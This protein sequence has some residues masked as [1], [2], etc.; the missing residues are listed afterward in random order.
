MDPLTLKWVHIVSSTVLFGTGLGTAFQGWF[1]HRTGEPKVIAAV[2]RNIVRAD[3]L[4]TATSG[5]IQPLSGVLLAR[6]MGFDLKESWLVA[7]FALYGL[8]ALCWF[9]VVWIQMKARD[10][11]ADAAVAGVP[12]PALYGRLMRLWFALGWPAFLALLGVFWLMVKKPALW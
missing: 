1:A 11:A 4:F 7:A 3:W 10:L 5:V 9:P 12:L 6:A 8:A 2:F